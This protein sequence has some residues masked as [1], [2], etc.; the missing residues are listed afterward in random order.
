MIMGSLNAIW[1]NDIM[2]MIAFSSVAQ[3]GYIYMGFANTASLIYRNC[4]ITGMQFLYGENVTFEN[5]VIDSS[6]NTGEPHSVW[7]YGAKN[8]NFIDCNFIY[9]DRAVN[10]YKDQ[11]I[12]GGKQVVNFKNCTFTTT[13]DT[14]E[15]AVEINS[16]AFSVGIEVNMDGCTAPANGDMVF[17]SKWDG[18][19]GA[20]TT[21]NVNGVKID[22]ATVDHD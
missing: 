18:T 10:C 15:G 4:H 19:D 20:M 12:D 2:R 22:N 13:S 9:G 11:D 3:I 1:E 8:I 16:S 6:A 14:S 7:T 21:I 5:C 17:I